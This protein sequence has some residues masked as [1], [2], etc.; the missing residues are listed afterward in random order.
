MESVIELPVSV[1]FINDP[2][3]KFSTTRTEDKIS[4]MFDEVNRIWSQAQIRFNLT[5]IQ[6]EEIDKN[7]LN[8]LI[9]LYC[10]ERPSLN[11]N[12]IDVYFVKEV[13]VN[14]EKLNGFTRSDLRRVFINDSTTVNDFCC[15]AH[16]F[17]HVLRLNDMYRTELLMHWRGN[18]QLQDWEIRIARHMATM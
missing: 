18:E 14:D 8:K 7:Q 15:V 16:E 3:N 1:H 11:S 12:L 10:Y 4:A 17:G 5:T 6:R 2:Q 13:I 9:D